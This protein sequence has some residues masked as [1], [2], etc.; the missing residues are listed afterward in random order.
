MSTVQSTFEDDFETPTGQSDTRT[1]PLCGETVYRAHLPTHL[2]S[3]DCGD[4]VGLKAGR[5]DSG[6]DA[7][8]ERT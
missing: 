1:C 8:G 5:S 6:T 7:G 3:D 2:A 4:D